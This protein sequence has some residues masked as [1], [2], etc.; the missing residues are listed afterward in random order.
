[1]VD[2]DLTLV[3]GRSDLCRHPT[4]QYPPR[5]TSVTSFRLT[6]GSRGTWM[7][8]QNNLTQHRV[9][10]SCTSYLSHVSYMCV[11]DRATTACSRA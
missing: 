3:Y 2:D 10:P 8:A 7:D 11:G 4:G 1:M 9:P 6:K 5:E